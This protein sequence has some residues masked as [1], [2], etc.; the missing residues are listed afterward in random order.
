MSFLTIATMVSID[1]PGV[2]RYIGVVLINIIYFDFLYTDQ[3]LPNLYKSMGI[4][5]NSDD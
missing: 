1:M 2:A 4:D 3:W 5:Y